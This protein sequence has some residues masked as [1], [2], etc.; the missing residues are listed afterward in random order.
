V[1]FIVVVDTDDT[2]RLSYI[3][4]IK[5][6]IPPTDGLLTSSIGLGDF[7][8][9]WAAGTWTP[10]SHVAD[11]KGAGI[12]FGDA[13]RRRESGRLDAEQLRDLWA[14]SKVPDAF[15][16]VH[17]AAV[18]SPQKGLTVGTDLL[19]V[20]PIYYYA[21]PEVILVGS[22][23]ELF[24]HHPC[25]TTKLSPEGLV[26]IFLTKG[27]V[28]G[29]TLLQGVKRLAP[30]HLLRCPPEKP[31]EETPQFKLPISNKFF[32]LTL[33]EQVEIV[34]EAM[35]EAVSRYVPKEEKHCLLLSGGLDSRLV[36]GY[37][38]KTANNV[39]TLT[40]GLPTDDDMRIAISTANSLGLRPVSFYV[41]P[42]HYTHLA[43]LSTTWHQLSD[44][45]TGVTVW[46][47]HPRLRKTAPRVVSGFIGDAIFGNLLSW[48]LTRS[49][50]SISF[51]T[52]FRHLNRPM[53][54]PETLGRLL[55]EEHFP[56]TVTKV[57]RRIKE[58]YESYSGLEFQRVWGFGLHHRVRFHGASAVWPLSFGSWPV[59]PYLDHKV[60][61]TLGGMPLQALA[62]R[63]LERELLRTKFPK[64][65]RLP[66]S[67]LG[68]DTTPIAPGPRHIGLQQVYGNVGIWRFG[69]LHALRNMLFLKLRGERR[70]WLRSSYFNS[71]G[72][73]EI[74]KKAE[75]CLDMTCQFLHEGVVS[76]LV[77]SSTAGDIT[78]KWR[79]VR[80]RIAETSSSKAILGFALWLQEHPPAIP[81]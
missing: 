8:A 1:N 69:P 20:F 23:P 34:D 77:P 19:G 9:I 28:D 37:L 29:Q 76:R 54:S 60:L 44:G 36:A 16:G 3:E 62:H 21:S 11:S 81:N 58:V 46:G 55:K 48:A 47:F 17:A 12:V 80:E 73:K 45:F 27:L 49:G 39:T 22:G 18:Y 68:L 2:R 42:S 26:G 13:I 7:H 70:F 52:F 32:N 50:K 33:S 41:Q 66:L 25:F 30:G 59:L 40:A 53:F 56:A 6:L 24:R 51:K 38:S 14:S 10:I 35:R 75:T 15:D 61:E 65:A 63:T 57:L 71:A 4:T 64:L 78:I 31:S 5:P 67:G 74:R 79:M 43:Q 72:W